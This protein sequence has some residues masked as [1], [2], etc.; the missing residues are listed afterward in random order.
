MNSETYKIAKEAFEKCQSE[1]LEKIRPLLDAMK[2]DC[3]LTVDKVSKICEG[4][5]GT[6]E[7][8]GCWNRYCEVTKGEHDWDEPGE[9]SVCDACGESK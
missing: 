9:Y 7:I 6:C 3:V 8:C 5:T 1:Y 4:K 2:H